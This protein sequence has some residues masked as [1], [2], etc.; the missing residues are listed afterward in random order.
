MAEERAPPSALDEWYF[1]LHGFSVLPQCLSAT[2][3]RE[4]NDYIDGLGQPFKPNG[5]WYGNV[6]VQSYY[7]NRPLEGVVD[8]G[9]NLQHI[10]EAGEC[11]TLSPQARTATRQLGG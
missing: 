2:E 7:A 5:E 11:V 4:I 6:Q 8:D 3:L 9:T 10:F 1:D